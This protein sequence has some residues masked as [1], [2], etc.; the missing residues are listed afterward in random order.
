MNKD[1]LRN[2]IRTLCSKEKNIFELCNEIKLNEY[3]ILALVRE[4][5]SDGINITTRVYDDDLY[6]FDNGEREASY[7]YNYDLNTDENHEFKFVAISDTRFG[8]KSQQLSILNDIYYKAYEEGYMNVFHCGNITEG[9][10]PVSNIYSDTLFL[11]DT[12]RQVD[13]IIKYYPS[14]PGMKTYFIT[15][16]KD[17]KHL[18]S[19]KINI[20]KRI[21]SARN[22]MIYLVFN[23]CNVNIDR[24][25][26]LLFNSKLGKTYTV[27]YRAQQQVDSF[28]SEDKPNILLYGGLLQ[29]EKFNYRNVNCISV[30]SV[31]ATT[32][33]M[34][35]KRYSNTVGAWYITIK[36]DEKGY[37]ESVR[38]IDS[39]YYSTIKDDYQK[40]KVLKLSN[41]K[42]VR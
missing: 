5:R 7:E 34:N 15:S 40:P 30:P 42:G 26:V 32:K 24:A 11:D 2:K 21:S 19:N 16:S 41:N 38:G 27:S 17:E 13:Y 31:C 12:L 10:Y 28:R 14:I 37:F 9:L 6:L 25:S 22:D 23:S 4:L 36:T 20:G 8:S 35:D 39:V 29:M 3:E 1:E 33:E 18:K